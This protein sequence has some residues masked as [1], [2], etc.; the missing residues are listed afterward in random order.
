MTPDELRAE[1]ARLGLSQAR[2]GNV[3]G[4][5]GRTVR[6]WAAGAVPIPRAVA[7]LLPK[8]TKAEVARIMRTM[9]GTG[10]EQ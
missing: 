8:L 5:D 4:A 2:A 9:R 3:L 1:L 6:R 10:D 7:L